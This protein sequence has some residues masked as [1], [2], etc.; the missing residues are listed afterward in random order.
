MGEGL[1]RKLAASCLEEN[2]IDDSV[3][4][5]VFDMLVRL[6]RNTGGAARR[7]AD[8]PRLCWFFL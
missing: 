2:P 4:N 5:R 1:R 8:V 6:S 7:S 3:S